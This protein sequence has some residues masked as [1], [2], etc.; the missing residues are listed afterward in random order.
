MRTVSYK[1]GDGSVHAPEIDVDEGG[2]PNEQ[3]AQVAVLRGVRVL[4]HRGGRCGA[5]LELVRRRALAALGAALPRGRLAAGFFATGVLVLPPPVPGFGVA[6]LLATRAWWR[7]RLCRVGAGFPSAHRQVRPT[8]TSWDTPQGETRVTDD[9]VLEAL[10]AL[11]GFTPSRFALEAELRIRGA[12]SAEA[13]Q[14]VLDAIDSGAIVIDR[15]G[16]VRPGPIP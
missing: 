4:F 12:S 7:A 10:D 5:G 15:L 1:S 3:P 2:R 14:A 13:R 16:S 9:E 11:G 6:F 8:Y